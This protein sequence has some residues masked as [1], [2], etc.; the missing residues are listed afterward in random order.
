[1]PIVLPISSYIYLFFL[2]LYLYLDLDLYLYLY[3]LLIRCFFLYLLYLYGDVSK[4]GHNEVSVFSLKLAILEPKTDTSFWD[5]SIYL[6]LYLYIAIAIYIDLYP[7]FHWDQYNPLSPALPPQGCP[8]VGCPIQLGG[9]ASHPRAKS[10]GGAL[11]K[12]AWASHTGSGSW[13]WAWQ[14]AR[15][16]QGRHR[17]RWWQQ[18][19]EG[20][21]WEVTWTD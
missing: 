2:Y 13:P 19:Q 21:S 3:L 17:K 1:M 12:P 6:C 20:T 5:I 11:A 15:K 10:F 18:T 4:W 16:G 9:P 7:I 8:W 14:G